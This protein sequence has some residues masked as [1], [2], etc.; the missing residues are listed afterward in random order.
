MYTTLF[1]A[2]LR[3]KEPYIWK[4]F[5]LAVFKTRSNS[6]MEVYSVFSIQSFM[7]QQMNI[8]IVYMILHAIKKFSL[9]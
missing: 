7:T 5:K 4:Q 3:L 2:I 8:N 9:F 1:L 6:S